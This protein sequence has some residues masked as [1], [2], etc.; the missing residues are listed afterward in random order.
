MYSEILIDFCW[1]DKQGEISAILRD[2]KKG[3]STNYY[4]AEDI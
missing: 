1:F 3:T 4:D 2:C